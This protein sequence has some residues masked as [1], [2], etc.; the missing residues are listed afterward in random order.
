MSRFIKVPVDEL[1]RILI[2]A[3]LQSRLGLAQA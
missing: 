1:G 3:E 2:P